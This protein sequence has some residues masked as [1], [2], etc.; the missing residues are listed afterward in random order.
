MSEPEP[1]DVV[2]SVTNTHKAKRQRRARTNIITP[3]AQVVPPPAKGQILFRLFP[4]NAT[5][6]RWGRRHG[7]KVKNS[8]PIPKE[9]R[10]DFHRWNAWSVRII[11]LQ[12]PGDTEPR[13]YF[14][15]MQGKYERATTTK[16]WRME[17]VMGEEL[18]A[19]L[20]EVGPDG[21]PVKKQGKKP[22]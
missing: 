6:R 22:R 18:F 10:E 4:D 9:V 19:M 8:G 11:S 14:K 20:R 16:W 13:G 15:L 12:R 17:N 1:T 7:F 3:D 21:K 5:L 2:W